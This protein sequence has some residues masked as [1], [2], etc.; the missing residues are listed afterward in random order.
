M[1]EEDPHGFQNLA[2]L[3]ITYRSEDGKIKINMALFRE[4]L[5]LESTS[6]V[7]TLGLPSV[8]VFGNA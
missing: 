1:G 5:S 2:D 4:K 7:D 6:S 8:P 3:G